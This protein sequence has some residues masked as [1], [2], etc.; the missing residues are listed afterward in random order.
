MPPRKYSPNPYAR[1]EPLAHL[2]EELLVADDLPRLDR[3]E[4]VPGVAEPLGRLLGVPL[5]VLDRH[6]RLLA[7][8]GLGL[9]LVGVGQD[10]LAGA[11][12]RG[13][14]ALELLEPEHV[15][16]VELVH[17]ALAK[18]RHAALEALRQVGEAL[19]AVLLV[20]LDRLVDLR[21]QGVRVGLTLLLVDPGDDRRRE[22]QDLLELLRREIEDVADPARERP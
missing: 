11:T 20:L 16:V 12:L 9:A 8:I 7:E 4:R 21:L 17:R 3:A 5:D 2:A 15:L 22:V 13:A 19:L 1:A 14:V 6:V 18:P 10:A